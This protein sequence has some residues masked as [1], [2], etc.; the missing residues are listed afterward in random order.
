MQHTWCWFFVG[1][2]IYVRFFVFR[3]GEKVCSMLQHVTACCTQTTLVLQTSANSTFPVTE[4]CME[5][6]L[7]TV[8]FAATS[9]F[10]ALSDLAVGHPHQ[11]MSS[12]KSRLRH[13]PPPSHKGVWC[14]LPRRNPGILI[15]PKVGAQHVMTHPYGVPYGLA[16]EY[17]NYPEVWR[18]ASETR[19]TKGRT[20]HNGY[21]IGF[22]L[23]LF[24]SL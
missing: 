9:L 22:R 2:V 21:Q 20:K 14:R 4:W 17:S 8:C 10:M 1:G 7:R 18:R 16:P 6:H 19:V 13:E 15:L 5:C 11:V 24:Q 23:H 12:G 3:D